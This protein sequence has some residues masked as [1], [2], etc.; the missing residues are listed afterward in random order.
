[1]GMQIYEERHKLETK[2]HYHG[3]H[4]VNFL[5]NNAWIYS[6]SYRLLSAT[7]RAVTTLTVTLEEPVDITQTKTSRFISE[8][9]SLNLDPILVN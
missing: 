4:D 2:F 8:L 3:N 7:K 9:G 6:H 5:P 1:M